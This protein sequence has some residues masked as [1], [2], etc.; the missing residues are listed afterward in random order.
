MRELLLIESFEELGYS[1]GHMISLVILPILLILGCYEIY[2]LKKSKEK[3]NFYY[4][5][6]N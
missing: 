4:N 1:L 3:K 2:L 5:R 6:R